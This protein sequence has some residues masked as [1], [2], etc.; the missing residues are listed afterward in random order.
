MPVDSTQKSGISSWLLS[1]ITERN[2]LILLFI[3]F[4]VLS[5][6]IALIPY[7]PETDVAD[8]TTNDIWI[9]HYPNGV[10][11]I[12]FDDWDYGP[13]QSVVVLYE[14]EYVVVNEKG[15]GHA[16]MMVPFHLIDADFLFGPLMVA[17]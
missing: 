3:L 6:L 14:G 15:P 2:C 7:N 11:H 1:K 10:Y 5:F 16:L 9:E 8:A 13:T 4:L 12:P 17:L